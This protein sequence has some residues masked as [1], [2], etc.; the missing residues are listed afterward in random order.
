MAAP[1]ILASRSP[2]RRR[3]LSVLGLRHTVDSADID[4]AMSPGESAVDYAARMAR[5]KALGVLG[6][7]PDAVV[8]G[9]DTVV[10]VE[11]RILG[12]PG[13]AAEA[14]AMLGRLSGRTHHV[15]TAVAVASRT[16]CE[17][18]VDTA[19]VHFAPISAAARDWYVA[20][21]EPADKA[22]AYAIQGIGGLFVTGVEGSPHT[23]VGLPIH[24]LEELLARSGL[25]LWDYLG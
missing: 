23:V 3:L 15:H 8:L 5:E 14:T 2:R 7:T 11:G 25:D 18:L 13:S 24:R 4:E 16:G 12:K 17:S 21:G 9:A 22:G 10:E 19:A 1:L 20:T 6:R